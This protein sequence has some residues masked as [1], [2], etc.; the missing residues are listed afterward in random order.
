MIQV[1]TRLPEE[2]AHILDE[3]GKEEGLILTRN[4]ETNRSAVIRLLLAKADE[5]LAQ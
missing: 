5:R 2:H 3:I 4:G 1:F